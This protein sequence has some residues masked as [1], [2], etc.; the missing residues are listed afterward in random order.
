LI[1]LNKLSFFDII[2]YLL[3]AAFSL[4]RMT[5]TLDGWFRIGAMSTSP[6]R[7]SVPMPRQALPAFHSQVVTLAL[8]QYAVESILPD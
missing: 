6:P 1:S 7:D 3:L 5:A 4:G 8:D 2:I